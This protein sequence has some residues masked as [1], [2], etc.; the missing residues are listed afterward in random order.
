MVWNS[1]SPQS[2]N[3]A[4]WNMH[5]WD[6]ATTDA[7]HLTAVA[8]T[9]AF[10]HND[11]LYRCLNR[12]HRKRYAANMPCLCRNGRIIRCAEGNRVSRNVQ[13]TILHMVFIGIVYELVEAFT[14]GL[15]VHACQSHSIPRLIAESP[16]VDPP[17]VDGRQTIDDAS[18]DREFRVGGHFRE[19]N[20]GYGKLFRHPTAVRR[21]V[22]GFRVA[23]HLHL[24]VAHD[25]QA[26]TAGRERYD[27]LVGERT[28]RFWDGLIRRRVV[29]LSTAVELDVAIDRDDA[30]DAT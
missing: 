21:G 2:S 3:H 8:R 28:E 12:R 22:G 24:S 1:S 16:F 19:M 23:K 14:G 18:T 30:S 6:S 26:E 7:Y 25:K 27:A 9:A 29:L 15:H 17:A 4:M 10:C 20:R 11:D 5:N 13:K